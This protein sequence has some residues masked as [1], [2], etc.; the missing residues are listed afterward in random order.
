M[1]INC[2]FGVSPHKSR[3]DLGNNPKKRQRNDED[4]EMNSVS[5]TNDEAEWEDVPQDKKP[6]K[7][8][9]AKR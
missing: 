7:V 8:I 2:I 6:R 1:G 3:M 5:N 4:Q 9:K